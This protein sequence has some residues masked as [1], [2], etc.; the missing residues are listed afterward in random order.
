MQGKICMITGASNG[1]GKASAI[2]LAE[3]G[4]SLVLLC[5][6]RNRGEEAAA[7]I[8][9]RS[10]NGDIELLVADLGSQSQ[11]RAA[12]ANFL[13]TGRP[14]H[15]LL[16][17]AG[18]INRERTVTGDGIE[19]TFAVN[20]LGPFLLT[21]LLLERLKEGA[22]ARIVNVS[23]ALHRRAYGD[24]RMVFDDLGGER[25]YSGYKAY[26]QSKLANI[27][28]T[29]ELARRLDGTGVT[30]NALHPGI[31]ATGFAG[32]NKNALWRFV[33]ATYRPFSLSPDKGAATSVWLAADP[34]LETVTGGY[35]HNRQERQPAPQALSDEDAA[36]L[37]EISEQ[38][39]GF[40]FA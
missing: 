29:R 13:E 40:E 23:S 18:L 14:L 19:T 11:I 2:R 21:G 3:M 17:N 31:V 26:G 33:R 15:V 27:L 4:A 1:I 38:M 16:N 22:P 10:G 35:F 8:G 28:F 12:A 39:T 24:G 5:R 7:E 32:N 37:W 6:D 34:A 36:R 30:V 9:A 25:E 20:H